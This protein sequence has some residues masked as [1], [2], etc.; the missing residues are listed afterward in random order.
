M[1][2]GWDYVSELRP[3]TALLFI[4]RVIQERGGSWW[5]DIDRGKTPD[6]S[7]QHQVQSESVEQCR[8]WNTLCANKKEL[9]Q[10]KPDVRRRENWMLSEL[11]PSFN[12]F[13]IILCLPQLIR[14]GIW[15]SELLSYVKFKRPKKFGSR[16]IQLLCWLKI[17]LKSKH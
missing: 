2:M 15:P 3:P 11:H 12:A 6:S 7:P 4:P 5:N 8:R 13:I 9:L 17:T 10:V 16:N 1:S 14:V